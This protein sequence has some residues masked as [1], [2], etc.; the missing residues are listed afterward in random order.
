MPIIEQHGVPITQAAHVA[1]LQPPDPDDEPPEL[2]LIAAHDPPMQVWPDA[3]EEQ[4]EPP[5]P[6]LLGSD[7]P[8][9]QLLFES[10]HPVQFD[11]EH[12]EPA[13]SGGVPL[14]DPLLVPLLVPLSSG[15]APPLLLAL[16]EYCIPPSSGASSDPFELPPPL[17]PEPPNTPDEPEGSEEI[18]HLP[19]SGGA[20][21]PAAHEVAKNPT[22]SAV[23]FPAGPR[24]RFCIF[25]SLR[26]ARAE[27]TP[28][29]IA[30]PTETAARL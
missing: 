21:S 27:T 9:W 16:L 3:H 14:L 25:G 1:A 17:V 23:S 18:T 26:G 24:A 10:Q 15:G 28:T 20:R 7:V 6:Q 29:R 8:G 4:A 12:P 13:S 22:K 19:A 2:V 11:A 30:T 5:E